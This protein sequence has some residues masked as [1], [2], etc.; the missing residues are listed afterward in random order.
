MGCVST[1]RLRGLSQ[2]STRLDQREAIVPVVRNRLSY[3][4]GSSSTTTTGV[5]ANRDIGL[6]GGS[7]P[8]LSTAR[9]LAAE[10]IKGAQ[11]RYKRTYDQRSKEVDYQLGDWVM[12]KFPQE[13]TGR[14]RK[15]SR[16]WH[17][18]YRI[19]DRRDPDV[20][21]VKIYA[22]QEGQIQVHQT[23]VAP[24]SPQLPAGFYWYWTRR[25]SPGRPPKWV[26]QL[27][28][29]EQFP[30]RQ[31]ATGPE[32]P[33]HRVADEGNS[34]HSSEDIVSTTEDSSHPEGGAEGNHDS[35]S[36]I[37]SSLPRETPELPAVSSGPASEPTSSRK[38][39]ADL[40][41][42]PG[43]LSQFDTDQGPTQVSLDSQPESATL[44]HRK[45]TRIS[46]NSQRTGDT[47]CGRKGNLR[48]G[49]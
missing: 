40:S 15:L 11:T 18:P 8:S 37:V 16:P 41:V 27:L 12:V 3:S 13:E 10:A 1:Q 24:C 43:L 19:I 45:T 6:P 9:R 23:R 4:Y 2:C 46:T 39:V 28:R 38:E 22:P 33:S 34:S 20:T 36:E 32:D 42:L 5:R 44:R 49:S 17:G 21:V 25:S 7:D 47:L 35:R 29:G 31:Q 26:D 30:Q 48:P 14:L